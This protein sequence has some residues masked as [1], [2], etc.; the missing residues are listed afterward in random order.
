MSLEKNGVDQNSNV[1]QH[2]ESNIHKHTQRQA[3]SKWVKIMKDD[4]VFG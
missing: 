1:V 3:Y 2:E 4:I